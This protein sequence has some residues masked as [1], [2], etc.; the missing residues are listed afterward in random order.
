MAGKLVELD[1]ILLLLEYEIAQNGAH[2]GS[3]A[4]ELTKS[5][6][7]GLNTAKTVQD[8]S[9]NTQSSPLDDS[10]VGVRSYRATKCKHKIPMGSSM[11]ARSALGEKCSST[12]TF[13]AH[14][15]DISLWLPTMVKFYG[16]VT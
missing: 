15:C 8:H 10:L 13:V 1:N 16:F 11:H 14:L 4:V 9:N 12:T 3:V 2:H 6:I 5:D 7:I